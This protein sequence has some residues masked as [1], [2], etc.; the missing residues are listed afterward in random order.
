[1]L[2]RRITKHVN[3]QNWFAVGIDFVIVVI[4][5]GVA[6]AAGEW[7]NAR[8]AKADLKIA[9]RAIHDELYINYLNALE[10]MAVKEC[11]AIQIRH[12]A[13]ALTNVEEPWKPLTT[14]LRDEGMSGELGNILRTPYR[15]AWPTNAWD[16]A[17]DS[18]LLSYMDPDRRND[19][20][21]IFSVSATISGYQDNA[22]QK[23]AELKSLLVATELSAADRLRYYDALAEFDSSGALIEVGAAYVI[24][25]VERLNIALDTQSNQQFQDDVEELNKL[26]YE[27]YGECFEPIVLPEKEGDR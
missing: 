8:A 1:M 15:G 23:T 27:A 24:S 17:G 16:A 11:S 26:G 18:N 6:L 19:I 20:S 3:E 9:E 12:I 22:F 7:V 4:G 5:V 14:L 10:R 2:R 13:Q 25:N 21:G